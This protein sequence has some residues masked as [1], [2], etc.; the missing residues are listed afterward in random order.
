MARRASSL[1]GREQILEYLES[2]EG[3][4]NKREIARAFGVKGDERKELREL[5]RDMEDK[6]LLNRRGGKRFGKTGK[7]PSVTVVEVRDR[8][9]DG[10]LICRPARWEGEGKPPRILL[11][12][13]EARGGRRSAAAL[14][15][16]D[17]FLAR[18][19]WSEEGYYEARVIK[20]I[21]QSAHKILGVYHITGKGK[22][23]RGRIQP[24]DR[25]A[26]SE[27][28][29]A[30][31]DAQGAKN[32]DL[33]LAE[34]L[35]MRT[36]G[37]KK[38]RVVERLGHM[39]D[40]RSVSLIA[41]HAHGIPHEFPEAVLAEA[42]AIKEAG[43]AGRTDLRKLPLIT[44]DPADARDHDD[45]VHAE[46]DPDPKN[47]GGFIVTVAIADVAAY[48]R[49]RSALEREARRRGNS[50]YFPDRVVPM[51]PERLS[52]DLCSL[53][54]GVDRAC[55]AV[56][57]TFT[58]DGR[59]KT[60]KFVRGV[61]RAAAGI[62]YEQ[63][64]AAIDGRP[65][66]V[67]K[68]LLKPVLKPLW[69]A[70]EVLAAGREKRQP[71]DLDLPEHRIEIGK[72]GRIKQ[73]RLRERLDAHRLIEEFMIQANVCAAQTL[74]R[75]HIP[76]LYRVHDVPDQEKLESLRG[77]LD[78]LGLTLPKGTKIRPAHFNRILSRA[79]GTEYG[80]LI[81]DVILRSQSQACYQTDNLGHF[82]LNLARYA[83]FTSPIRRYADLT[84]HRGLIRA[85]GL[86]K[87][88]LTDEEAGE[89]GTIGEEISGTERR[90]MAAERESTDR[91]MAAYLAD[92]VGATFNGR[93]AGVTRFGLFIRLDETGADGLVPIA[94]L[95]ND[96][97]DHDEASHAL[98]GRFTGAIH[99]LGDA[100]EVRLLEAAPVT[101]GLR[102]ELLSEPSGFRAPSGKRRRGGPGKRAG[103][104]GRT[105]KAASSRSGKKGGNSRGKA[106]KDRKAAK[107]K[108]K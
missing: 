18:L 69:A 12:P 100:A 63:A 10:E 26:R 13:G 5:L 79:R 95:G 34:L 103:S 43:P 17:R 67:T 99:R 55:L 89:L 90:A 42:E 105:R 78:G 98:V 11:V 107:K 68:P 3:E 50:V 65:D 47:P 39:S 21:G 8:D 14:G 20:R 51:L 46:P 53:M 61:M 6:G 15:V 49:P 92:R 88:G 82:G 97:Y 71:L 16:G 66:E 106:K 102:F 48:I 85:L 94:S 76:L 9:A 44:I 72:D 73:V 22:N 45:A 31:A 37:P 4:P 83:H 58:A 28:E 70:Y 108:R 30:S 87:D 36:Y 104:A 40:S 54:D 1:P 27:P 23:A 74:E 56:R 2:V 80:Q 93:V 59:K 25:R 62:S 91:Y 41:I 96:H 33:V 57:M 7:L 24:V 101:G 86:G 29:V 64:Q 60:H 35:P 32:G 19:Q 77:F 84:V 52:A 81:S 75:R 38:A